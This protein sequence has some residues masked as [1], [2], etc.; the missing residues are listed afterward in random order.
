MQAWLLWLLSGILMAILEI[1]T[2]GFVLACF[3]IGCF[4]AA[5]IAALD[6][7]VTIQVATFT[8][9]T[10]IVFISARP[11]LIEW[12]GNLKSNV[13][14]NTERLVGM[15]GI[16]MEE[17]SQWRGSVSVEGEIWNSRSVD[18][19]V[20]PAGTEVRIVK[21]DGNKLIVCQNGVHQ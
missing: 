1:V 15:T 9:V 4:S 6:F 11:I 13:L 18:E 5:I 12:M 2:P 10:F 20:L 16:A 14:T 8:A 17:V 21:I 19:Q 3:S 7:N